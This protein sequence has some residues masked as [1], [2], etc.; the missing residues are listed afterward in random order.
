[1]GDPR[2]GYRTSRER[3]LQPLTTYDNVDVTVSVYIGCRDRMTVANSVQHGPPFPGAAAPE[4]LPPRQLAVAI[5][6][7][8]DVDIAIV[9]D[10]SGGDVLAVEV[11]VDRVLGPHRP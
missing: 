10:V 6:Y 4:V 9:V 2:V 11:V 7:R 3:I 1:M 8:C 5:R